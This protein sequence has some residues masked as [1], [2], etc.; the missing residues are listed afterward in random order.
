MVYKQPGPDPLDDRA[1]HSMFLIL[2]EINTVF[3][4]I[5]VILTSLSA[6]THAQ[7]CPAF[8]WLLGL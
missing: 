2:A 6:C 1:I 5:R 7:S 8:L 4:T 3:T